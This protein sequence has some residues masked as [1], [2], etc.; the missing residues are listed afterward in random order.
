MPRARF[1][2]DMTPGELPDC[3]RRL[4]V[5][6]SE[7]LERLCVAHALGVLQRDI[8]LLDCTE[9]ALHGMPRYAPRTAN[10]VD[11]M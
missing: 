11:Q 8:P 9:R 1:P 4:P 3:P 2:E 10:L 6:R 5:L 7:S